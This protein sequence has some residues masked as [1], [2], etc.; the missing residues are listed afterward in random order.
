MVN[1]IHRKFYILG[2]GTF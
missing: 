1:T 2:C